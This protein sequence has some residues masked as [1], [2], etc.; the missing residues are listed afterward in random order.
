MH[1]NNVLKL[2]FIV[3]CLN[4]TFAEKDCDDGQRKQMHKKFT[5]CTEKY[6]QKFE[7]KQN[8]DYDLETGEHD[9]NLDTG[10][11]DA[12]CGLFDNLIN[13]CGNIWKM[14]HVASE[15]T[16]MKE[17]Q[18]E[19]LYRHYDAFYVDNCDIVK[20]YKAKPFAKIEKC[21][22]QDGIISQ[23][24]FQKCS[25]NIS[26]HVYQNIQDMTDEGAITQYL[27]TA[28][29][30]IEESCS[31]HLSRCFS[32]KDCAHILHLHLEEIEHFFDSFIQNLIP[33]ARLT[34]CK[35]FSIQDGENLESDDKLV[36]KNDYVISISKTN[37]TKGLS[38]DNHDEHNKH[39]PLF[40]KPKEPITDIEKENI[41]H[42]QENDEGKNQIEEQTNKIDEGKDSNKT[43]LEASDK[44]RDKLPTSIRNFS[45]NNGGSD[46]SNI[47]YAIDTVPEIVITDKTN[48]QESAADIQNKK[49][50]ENHEKQY[51]DEVINVM[52]S[53]DPE[54][55]FQFGWT[56]WKASDNKLI[57]PGSGIQKWSDTYDDINDDDDKVENASPQ[58][59]DA[60][61]IAADSQTF[62]L[63][64]WLC[65]LIA[66]KLYSKL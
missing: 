18:I 6:Y 8:D 47:S 16:S 38:V 48:K 2:M 51:N 15:V 10:Q 23:N 61:N 35:S 33:T 43:D 37:A 26:S 59:S 58:V 46:N 25:H 13:V 5:E 21:S 63:N 4:V 62:G 44:E 27:C 50:L 34:D 31:K 20:K 32:V 19:S 28:L 3:I 1:S 24:L 64:T 57:I 17:M 12:F 53:V 22:E 49:E 30:K 45:N 66:G 56:L 55:E 52:D 9:V 11:H 65:V 40:D 7:N 54:A 29:T 14:C 41:K 42:N 60:L 36:T 39:L